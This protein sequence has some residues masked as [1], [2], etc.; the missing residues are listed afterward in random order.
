MS[1]GRQ[2]VISLLSLLLLFSGG[3]MSLFLPPPSAKLIVSCAPPLKPT[4]H[5]HD[6]SSIRHLFFLFVRENHR[7]V[8]TNR[9]RFA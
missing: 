4:A 9:P 8:F 3:K 5:E 7:G 2:S 6:R 1:L